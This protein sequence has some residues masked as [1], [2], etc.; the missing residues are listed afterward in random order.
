MPNQLTFDEPIT[1]GS[2]KYARVTL[3]REVDDT[4]KRLVL[5]IQIY[6]D[7]GMIHPNTF[8]I[9]VKN[10]SCGRLTTAAS[11]ASTQ[12]VIAAD[13]ITVDDNPDVAN[14]FDLVMGQYVTGGLTAVLDKLQELG[15][16]PEGEAA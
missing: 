13:E 1:I 15:A 2:L 7:D 14:A 4:L 5:D 16:L 6:G 12:E 10:G 8:S 3:A 9:E 11:P